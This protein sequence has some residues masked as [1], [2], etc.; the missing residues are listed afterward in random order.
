ML[1]DDKHEVALVKF[2]NSKGKKPLE[3][4]IGFSFVSIENA[5]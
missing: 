5:K 2:I 1:K 4:K 3:L